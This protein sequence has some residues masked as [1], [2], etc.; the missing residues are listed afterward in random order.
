MNNKVRLAGI[1]YESLVNGP[2]LRRVFFSQGCTHKCKGCFNPE[3]HDFNG[4]EDMDMD[5]T[6]RVASLRGAVAPAEVVE[7]YPDLAFADIF[8]NYLKS[9]GETVTAP[10]QLTIVD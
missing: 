10:E 6:Y 8:K 3:T 9:A 7:E 4:G 1:A 5:Q 2:G